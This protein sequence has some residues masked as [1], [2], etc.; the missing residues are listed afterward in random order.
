MSADGAILVTGAG[1]FVG[2]WLVPELVKSGRPVVGVRKPGLPFPELD[3]E[4]FEVDLRE[5]AEV[6][7][8]V[9]TVRPS[10]VLHLAAIAVPREAARDPVD[11]LRM[12][13]GAVDHLI[14]ALRESAP[15]A[16]LLLVS[17]GEVYGPRPADAPPSRESDPTR[18]ASV[19]AASKLAAEQAVAVDAFVLNVPSRLCLQDLKKSFPAVTSRR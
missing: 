2:S 8:V 15:E 17:T 19:Y 10:A 6:R 4:W 1:G 12:N 3:C 11:T 18:P 14:H 5:R 9:R 7:E 13:F 16:R